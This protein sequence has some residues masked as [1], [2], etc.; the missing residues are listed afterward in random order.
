MAPS[1]LL[2]T[3]SMFKGLKVIAQ[4]EKETLRKVWLI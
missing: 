3:S 1:W 2:E 4:G